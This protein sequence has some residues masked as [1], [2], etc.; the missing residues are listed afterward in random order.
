MDCSTAKCYSSD[1]DSDP[2]PQGHLSHTLTNWAI[3]PLS[4]LPSNP[5]NAL[6]LRWFQPGPLPHP[7]HTHTYT[8]THCHTPPPLT[9]YT[10]IR[11]GHREWPKVTHCSLNHFR[12]VKGRR[13]PRR[14]RVHCWSVT[15]E[16]GM[17]PAYVCVSSSCDDVWPQIDTHIYICFYI[18]L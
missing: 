5:S 6:V 12:S 3:S 4:W 18:Y 10:R 7:S 14:M 2:S 15:M 16:T 13:T 1:R 9:A 17:V 8:P 11:S